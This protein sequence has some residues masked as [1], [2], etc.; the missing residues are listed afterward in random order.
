MSTRQP[1]SRAAR[2]AFWPSL[3]IASESWKSGTIT[4][5][6]PVSSWMRTSRTFAGA[7]ARITNSGGVVAVGND[8]DLLAAQLVHDLSDAHAARTDA[9]ADRVDVLVV[10]RDRELGAVTGLARDGLDLDDAVDELGH[11]E[12]E[13]PPHET[14]VRA[15]HDDLRTL[16]R[17]AHL[18]DVR[19]HARAVVVPVARDLLG[20]RQQRLDPTEVE[21]RVARVGLLDDAGDD[22]AFAAG[23]LLV[24]HLALGLADALQDD[25]LRRLRGDAAEVGGR[26]VPL[27]GDVALFVELLRDHADLAGLDVDL[28][29]RFLGRFGHALVRGDE[30]VRQRLEH[31]LFGDALLDARARRALRASRGSSCSIPFARARACA[32]VLA[33]LG[34]RLRAPLEHGARLRDVGDRDRLASPSSG[35]TTTMSASA[36]RERAAARDAGRRRCGT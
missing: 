24:L 7:S 27:A 18:D 35:S 29:E 6:M 23:V 34:A 19:L 9:R 5:A 13:Q 12:L 30:R 11:L 15:R 4:S 8:V 21:Q 2:R 26:V 16:R 20:L 25:L 31:D 22:V 1:V 33:R 10:R 32:F 3:P 28:D 17:L 14:G 36:A